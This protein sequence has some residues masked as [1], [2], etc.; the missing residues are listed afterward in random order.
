MTDHTHDEA[1]AAG[2]L[3]IEKRSDGT[4]VVAVAGAGPRAAT[5]PAARFSFREGDPQY[6]YWVRRFDAQARSPAPAA[7][8]GPA[9]QAGG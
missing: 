2:R 4:I 8:G 7:D 1:I 3:S 9:R 5:L 6:A